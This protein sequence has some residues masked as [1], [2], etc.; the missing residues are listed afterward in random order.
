MILETA[1]LLLRPVEAD[2]IGSFFAIYGDPQTNLF[3][4]RGPLKDM[5]AAQEKLSGWLQEW[6]DHGF[7]HWAIALNHKPDEIIG[8]GG[9][10]I[11]EGYENHRVFLGYRFATAA[12]GKGLATEFATAVLNT[13]FEKLG[14]PQISATVRENHLASQHVLEK[15]GMQKTGFE[16]DPVHGIGSYLYRQTSQY[17]VNGSTFD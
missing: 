15:I 10:G 1:R 17:V 5:T 4:P 9:L 8:F 11:R 13:G 6:S 12:W 14:I 7:G 16:G 3:N 2:D